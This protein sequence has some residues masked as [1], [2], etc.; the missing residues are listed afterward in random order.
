MAKIETEKLLAQTVMSE[1]EHLAKHGKYSGHFAPQFHSYGYEGRS[2][3]PSDFDAIYCYALGQNAAA[4]LRLGC[5]GLISS[6]TGF[7][8]P[9]RVLAVRRRAHH[10][11]VPH[12]APQRPY[13]GFN[14][15][16]ANGCF[17]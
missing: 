17:R 3:L 6:V 16:T 11:D 15:I 4:L 7:G 1:L 12:G 8:C 9:S 14:Y 5:N 2:C 10:H 13:E